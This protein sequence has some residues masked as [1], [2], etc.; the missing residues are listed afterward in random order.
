MPAMGEGPQ[1]GLI[2]LQG[3]RLELLAQAV[4]A[5][6]ARQPLAPLEQEVVL[7][8]SN[9]MAEW[10][11][12]AQ[13]QA[14]GICAATRVEL[15]AR[16]VWRAW[17][18]VLGRAA[19][20][21]A[22]PFDK[23]ALC[24]RLMRLLPELSGQPGFEPLAAFLDGG[25]AGRRLQLAQRL[26][27][28][29][30]QYQVYRADWLQDW[31]QERDV[32]RR[33]A[34]AAH[35]A[36][37]DEPAELPAQ[38]RW[39]PALWRALLADMTPAQRLLSRP[40]LQQ[41][42]LEALSQSSPQQGFAGLPRRIVVFG[43][44]HVPL[45][46]LEAI[47]AL[48]GR[49]QVLM[50]VP[51][52]CRYHWADIIDG[53]E[54][55]RLQHWRQPLRG[56]RE[57]AALPLSQM[58][59]HGHPLL[60]A[61]GRQSRDFV[62]QLDAFDEA[63]AARR[64]QPLPK[65]DLFDETPPTSL[66][67]QVQAAVRDL[68][69]LA[70]HPR[71][72]VP[73]SDR[74]IVFHL[75][76]SAQREVEILHD[77][78]LALLAQPPG[79]QPLAPRDIVVMVPDIEVFGAAIRSVFGQ[80]P[81]G[82]PRHIPWGIADQKERGNEPLLVA[83]EYLLRLPQQRLAASEL[84]ALL[85]VPAIARRF[86]VAAD[87]VPTIAQWLDGAGVRWGLDAAHRDS[88]G[89]GAAGAHNT[90][91]FGLQRMLLGYAC[92]ELE[93]APGFAGIEPYAEVAGLAATLA[94]S[95]AELVQTLTRWRDEVDASPPPTP[96][97]WAPRLRRLL[98]DVFSASDDPDRALLQALDDALAAWLQ[99]CEAAGF[100]EPTPLAVLREAWLEALEAP[101]LTHRFQAGGV[102]FCTL[103]PLRAIPYPVLC[104]L[105]MNDGAYPRR[106]VRSDFDLMGG[107]AGQAGQAGQVRPGDRS[108][109]DDDRQLML[110][111]LLSARRVLY[112]SWAG[113]SARDNQPQPPSVLVA[114]LRD[115]LA[116]G[117]GPQVLA[118]RSTEHPL[119]PFSR[120]YFEPAAAGGRLFTHASEWRTAHTE[121]ARPALDAARC[122]KGRE[123][124]ADARGTRPF[125]LGALAAFLRN[126]VQA[127]YRQR[128]QVEFDASAPGQ[129]DEE[130]FGVAALERWRLADEVLRAC[131]A[132]TQ[133]PAPQQLQAFLQQQ[134]ERL[135]RSGRLPL[136]GPGRRAQAELA[137]ALLPVLGA[138]REV[139]DAHPLACDKQ[140]LRWSCPQ[141]S[142]LVLDDW[143]TGLRAPSALAPAVWLEL[144]SGKLTT[145]KG[146]PRPDRLL[147]AWL[148]ALASA[149]CADGMAQGMADDVRDQA[150]DAGVI[151]IVVGADALVRVRAP[152]DAT[153]TLQDLLLAYREGLGG[154]RPWPT[155]L[156]TG[157]AWLDDPASARAVY[158]GQTHSPVAGEGEEACLARSHPDFA[159]LQAEPGF[160][161]VTRRLY[162]PYQ[163]WLAQQVEIDRHAAAGP[164]A[165]DM[166]D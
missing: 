35:A 122:A 140:P 125:T 165:E 40:A 120:R 55:L 51:N 15:P 39:Q 1:A 83:L 85:E 150:A 94:G 136:A 69:P 97:Q 16:F 33:A 141:D 91:D 95:L 22:S 159:S 84:R 18:A 162:Q 65:V 101:E 14:H 3:N 23:L 59:A 100:D 2:V 43:S 7:V 127:F 80:Y 164:Q 67:Q 102:T 155:A 103:L 111:A 123:A 27:D 88:L 47:T 38:Q 82:D 116:S 61:W 128:L 13:A 29:L 10:F 8:Q 110:D 66:L 144:Q 115:Y 99:A 92:G 57:L 41:R 24:W 79:G 104:L 9:G 129:E 142:S 126:P 89:L 77:Q 60:A 112:L 134:L 113:R 75:A 114:Q 37:S 76:H 106:A 52:P 25:D 107:Q 166:N 148:R 26:A 137:Q 34:H 161:S 86:G 48:A 118:E 17:R 152:L 64:Q 131:R 105:G 87:D 98:A 124:G 119:Q 145:K 70:E 12:M 108:R 19:L 121:R 156:R 21:A 56:G 135:R 146:A 31:E 68:L 46:T 117:W 5:W 143:L 42:F 30:D 58:H 45:Q 109:R 96:T 20:P 73:A 158:E 93:A 157:L 90:W 49:C 147:A 132:W 149:A 154:D 138:W 71:Q 81:R 139:L 63:Q 6:L 160:E 36:H 53:R 32:L 163:A 130:A 151:G 74:S 153:A 4:F 78:L 11:K 72:A 62:R 54:L 133:A 50:A 44:T 28:L